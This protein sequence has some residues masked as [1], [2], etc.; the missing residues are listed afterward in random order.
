MSNRIIRRI[1]SIDGGGIKGVFPASFLAT[2]EEELP[3]PIGEYFDLIVGTSTGGI[4]AIGLGL[5]F[6]AS[7]LLDFYL[8]LGPDVFAGNRILKF[9]R[10]FGIAKYNP[11]LLEEK[12]VKK[13]GDRKI[14]ESKTRLVIPSMNLTTLDVHIYKTSHHERLMKDY[15]RPVVEAAMATA[16]APTF[17]P[18]Y[19]S[20]QGIPFID[21]GLWANN[22][23]AV[24]AVEALT[25]LGWEAKE[26]RMLSIGCTQAPPG[27][28]WAQRFS[29]GLVYWGFKAKDA[30]MG[31]Q[32]S[33]AL[34]MAQHLLG[35]ENVF[36]INPVVPS[37]R[38]ALDSVKELEGLRG[39]GYDQARYKISD[40]MPIFFR[41]PVE[42]F[43]PFHKV[44]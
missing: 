15:R 29:L 41:E 27:I 42:P 34:G 30:F 33:G 7:E 12:L 40:L 28:H 32:A 3:Q 36:R 14:G 16:A 31:G 39:L 10:W 6:S 19:K 11:Q 37:G 38:Y 26:V 35:K 18:S 13:F 4:I 43:E 1:L 5:G 8:K 2:I 24:A 44:I 25:I 23:M 22:P 21:G 9:F 17:F 20:A